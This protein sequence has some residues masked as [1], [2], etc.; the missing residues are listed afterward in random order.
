MRAASNGGHTEGVS[1]PLSCP[2]GHV[3]GPGRVLVGWYP[4]QCSGARGGG[5]RTWRCRVCDAAGHGDENLIFSSPHIPGE[6]RRRG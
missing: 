1:A 5:H 3:L 2:A 6:D 4:C